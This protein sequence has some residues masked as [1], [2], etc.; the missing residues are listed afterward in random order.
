[1]GTN[2]FENENG[3]CEKVEEEEE[4]IERTRRK[5][6]QH[7]FAYDFQKFTSNLVKMPNVSCIRKGR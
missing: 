1:M 6:T 3:D 4:K 7:S 2:R 5:V